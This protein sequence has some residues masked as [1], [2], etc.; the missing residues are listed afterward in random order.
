MD[1]LSNS[2]DRSIKI[3]RDEAMSSHVDD[4]LNRQ[5]N[6]IGERRVSSDKRSVWYLQNWFLFGLAGALAAFIMWALLEPYYDDLIYIQGRIEEINLTEPMPSRIT[7]GNQIFEIPQ[8]GYGWIT[9]RGQRI[10]LSSTIKHYH[11]SKVLSTGLP[12]IRKGQEV[13]VFLEYFSIYDTGRAIATHIDPAPQYPPPEKAT[14][15]LTDLNK[16]ESL[17]SFILFPLIAGIIGLAIGAV[18]GLICRNF[19]RA[20][21]AGL[22]GMLVGLLGGLISLIPSSIVY[23]LMNNFAMNQA[24]ESNALSGAAFFVQMTGRSIAWG[25]AGIAMGLGQGVALRSGRLLLYGLMGGVMGGLIGGLLFDPIDM[26]FLNPDDP[27]AH[28]SRMTGF[29]V[30]G[31]SVGV[32]IGIVQLLA[33]DAWLRMTHGP[34]SGKEFLFF[35]DKMIIGASPKCEIYVFNDRSVSEQHAILRVVGDSFEI[36]SLVKDRPVVVNNS[37]ITRSRLNH[38][39]QIAIGNTIFLFEMKQK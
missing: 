4:I 37:A 22:I 3:T 29:T 13:G 36:E 19:G 18:E 14:L 35:K 24:A 30:I 7:S 31:L 8:T 5:K 21:I 25:L 11:N 27:S 23:Q 34:L 1:H 39:D 12:E 26:I 15:S 9:I 28:W 20:I 33:R 38:G 17:L 6:L 2:P 10:W 16:R 32:M